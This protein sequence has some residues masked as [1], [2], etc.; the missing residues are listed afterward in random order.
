MAA[1]S[2]RCARARLRGQAGFSLIELLVAMTFMAVA[3]LAAVSTFDF[4]R[5]QTMTG[6]QAT[7][8]AH[9]AEA[10]TELIL[11]QPYTAVGLTTAPA[12]TSNGSPTDKVHNGNPPTFSYD[13]S[14]LGTTEQL[15]TAAGAAGCG[16]TLQPV[17]AWTDGR[18]SGSVY[19]FVTWTADPCAACANAKDYKRI[20]VIVTAPGRKPF[21]S[22]TIMASTG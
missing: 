2:D 10:E 12:A 8:L 14:S 1:T 18:Y 20:T 15:V 4:T 9:R 17:S 3:I 22:S 6:E 11:A 5:R 21:I 19:R 7:V 16:C 13:W